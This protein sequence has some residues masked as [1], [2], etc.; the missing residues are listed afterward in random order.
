MWADDDWRDL[1]PAAQH[2]YMVLLSHPTLTYAGVADWR[3]GRIASLSR[4][5]AASDVLEAAVE[6]E[7][8]HFILVDHDSEEV[9]IRSFVKHDGLMKQPKL[10]VAMA[11]A[12]AAVASASIRQVVAFEV[13]KLHSREPN[14]SAWEAAQVKTILSAKGSP[15]DTFTPAFTPETT[16]AVT[17]GRGQALAVPTTTGTTTETSTDV[18]EK[19]SAPAARGTRLS[20]S[21]MPSE[22]LLQWARAERSDI[23]PVKEADAFRDYWLS[24]PGQKGVKTDW[25]RTFKNWIR[26][27][28]GR[29]ARSA[30]VTPVDRMRQT[31]ALV[32]VEPQWK[33]LA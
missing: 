24:Q 9:L 3:P 17:P 31:L 27:A 20:D 18:D 7:Q 15:I 30:P 2:L 13:Q 6:L 33:E 12:Y 32:P 26:N 8:A 25:D 23:D 16:P 11:N 19:K 14:L 28:R 21:W 10:A 5:W 29:A 4:G 1:T 22:D